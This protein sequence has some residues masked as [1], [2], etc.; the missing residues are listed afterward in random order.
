MW[1]G[2]V[3]PGSIH[4]NEDILSF[5]FCGE[6]GTGAGIELDGDVIIAIWFDDHK[7]RWTPPRVG[8][9]FHTSF[10]AHMEEEGHNIRLFARHLDM[11]DS[12]NS[13]FTPHVDKL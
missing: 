9:A 1:S 7:S 11:P 13:R 10:M 2:G 3:L 4:A 6:D 8:Y 12:S 5:D